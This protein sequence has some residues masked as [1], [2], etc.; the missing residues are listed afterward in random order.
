MS[1]HPETTGRLADKCLG[2]QPLHPSENGELTRSS[3]TT[4]Y[5]H[6]HGRLSRL[7]GTGRFSRNEGWENDSP[8]MENGDG[9]PTLRWSILPGNNRLWLIFFSVV[10]QTAY[11]VSSKSQFCISSMKVGN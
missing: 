2:E 3:H 4:G 6:L 9:K 5:P 10:V 1:R 11:Y 8:R 7:E